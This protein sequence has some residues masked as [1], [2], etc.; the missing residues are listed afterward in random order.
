M[1]ITVITEVMVQLYITH[2]VMVQ[3]KL[4]LCLYQ[5]TA[6]L[7]TI[8]IEKFSVVIL[9]TEYYLSIILSFTVLRFITIKLVALL[10]L[11]MA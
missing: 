1:Y 7:V 2:Q 11:F 6:V 10:H 3:I 9:S 4:N 8:K 5:V